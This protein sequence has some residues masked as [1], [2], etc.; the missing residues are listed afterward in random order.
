MH[1]SVCAC[2]FA[3]VRDKHTKPNN[4]LVKGFIALGEFTLGFLPG[5]ECLNETKPK[6]SPI[7]T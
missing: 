3:C 1:L 2:V 6:G 5:M 7:V 4:G